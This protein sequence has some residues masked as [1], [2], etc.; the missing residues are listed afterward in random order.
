MELSVKKSAVPDRD[1]CQLLFWNILVARTCWPLCSATDYLFNGRGK[2]CCSLE[3][4]EI[5]CG[6]FTSAQSFWLACS[7]DNCKSCCLIN[8]ISSQPFFMWLPAPQ[9]RAFISLR[10]SGSPF[11]SFKLMQISSRLN[12]FPPSLADAYISLI[13]QYVNDKKCT[14]ILLTSILSMHSAPLYKNKINILLLLRHFQML[15]KTSKTKCVTQAYLK[16]TMMSFFLNLFC[17][18]F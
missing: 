11:Y 3:L 7:R 13:T 8:R 9:T 10:V 16:A 14:F 17:P 1:L 4:V 2:I 5:D 12:F 18:S 6:L 15:A